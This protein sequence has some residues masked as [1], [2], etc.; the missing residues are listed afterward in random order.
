MFFASWFCYSHIYIYIDTYVYIYSR[1]LSGSHHSAFCFISISSH[2]HTPFF[3]GIYFNQFLLSKPMGMRCD[4]RFIY[5][6]DD[7]L[8]CPPLPLRPPS[9]RDGGALPRPLPVPPPPLPPPLPRGP[10]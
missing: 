1:F 6:P 10:R 8:D 7:G 5:E 9:V 4:E 2:P 3:L